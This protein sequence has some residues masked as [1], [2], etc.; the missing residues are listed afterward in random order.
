MPEPSVMPEIFSSGISFVMSQMSKCLDM[1]WLD[2]G[3]IA[4]MLNDA[5]PLNKC[6]TVLTSFG[7]RPRRFGK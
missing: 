1:V 4:K 2:R 3:R 5:K 7:L 6:L